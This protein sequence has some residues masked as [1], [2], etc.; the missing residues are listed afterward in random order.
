M[1]TYVTWLLDDDRILQR[2]DESHELRMKQTNLLFGNLDVVRARKTRVSS[3]VTG[4]R[5]VLE[6][7]VCYAPCSMLHTRSL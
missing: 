4:G 6:M 5:V 2:K 1:M 7:V 3:P